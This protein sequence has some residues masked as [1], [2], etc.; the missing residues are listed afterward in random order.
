MESFCFDS[1]FYSR[2]LI[3]VKKI[4]IDIGRT[5]SD[6]EQI[7]ENI[8][9]RLTA[10]EKEAHTLKDC[11]GCL[12][13]FQFK[14]GLSL[15]PVSK[16]CRSLYMQKPKSIVWFVMVNLSESRWMTLQTQPRK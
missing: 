2:S 11:N 1:K 10:E 9:Q 13:D 7:S 6:K 5:V 15:F 4:L 16:L 14:K 12:V 3:S 8:L